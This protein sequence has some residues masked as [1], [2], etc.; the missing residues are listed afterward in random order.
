M[1]RA[2]IYR[3]FIK[4]VEV[5]LSLSKCYAQSVHTLF[6]QELGFDKACTERV[7]VLTL[8]FSFLLIISTLQGP[9]IDR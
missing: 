2:A 9:V 5:T 1:G 6:I 7:E 4:K 3:N 8:T